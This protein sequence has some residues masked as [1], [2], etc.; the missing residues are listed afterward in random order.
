[1]KRILLFSLSA[2][3]IALTFSS[4]SNGPFQGGAG[5][6][7][8]SAGTSASCSGGGCH[9]ANS[10]NTTAG[11][12]LLT[13]S[14]GPVSAYT[15]GVTYKVQVIGGN[16]TGL[17]KFGFQ[18]SCAKQSATSTKA[19]TF[20]NAT[21]IAV[22]NATGSM[23][24]VEHTAPLAGNVAGGQAAYI[25]SFNWTA[26]AK[27][28]GTVRFYVTLNAVNG[29]GSVTGDQPATTTP[30]DVPEAPSSSI[31]SVERLHLSVYPNPTTDELHLQLN[32]ADD[33]L[34][35]VFDISGKVASSQSVTVTNGSASINTSRLRAGNYYV[36]LQQGS[37]QY[38]A[39]F[40]KQ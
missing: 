17:P 22:R 21:N 13:L 16:T 20:A 23:P 11:I 35:H 12:G 28:T 6:R 10:A 5:N 19:G 37:Q 40:Q 15:P 3:I 2:G 8:G 33:C 34:V 4:Y 29:N 14:N 7:T 32:G 9:D 24:V 26:P 30:L 27:G 31:A 39:T 38:G 1:M 18:V 25:T 36:L